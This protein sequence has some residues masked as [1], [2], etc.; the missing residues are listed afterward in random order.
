MSL[1]PVSTQR[2]KNYIR[3]NRHHCTFYFTALLFLKMYLMFMFR[4]LYQHRRLQIRPTLLH[5]LL[6]WCDDRQ[7]LLSELGV[8]GFAS[9]GQ[10]GPDWF[11]WCSAVLFLQREVRNVLSCPEGSI[12]CSVIT[13]QH[14]DDLIWGTQLQ[15][16]PWW[17]SNIR[18]SIYHI[19]NYYLILEL[20][21]A[22][23]I[24][25]CWWDHPSW[26][27]MDSIVAFLRVRSE[28]LQ[29]S[30]YFIWSLLLSLEKKKKKGEL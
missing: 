29:T 3:V 24:F 16:C 7:P 22:M 21:T 13:V 20:N 17:I 19:H 26:F 8:C 9:S 2:S 28:D 23:F 5:M 18:P 30:F 15:K 1:W 25:L 4:S 6:L 11:D 27:A 10:I 14:Y 12:S